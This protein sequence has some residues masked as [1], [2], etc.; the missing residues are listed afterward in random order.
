MW[1][2]KGNS[3]SSSSQT[4]NQNVNYGWKTEGNVEKTVQ[5]STASS[6]GF[7]WNIPTPVPSSPKRLM[8]ISSPFEEEKFDHMEDDMVIQEQ[9]FTCKEIPREYGLVY[10]VSAQSIVKIIIIK[11]RKIYVVSSSVYV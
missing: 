2:K 4:S 6:A 5:T 7:G 3:S 10:T 8:P 9:A 11:C 1:N